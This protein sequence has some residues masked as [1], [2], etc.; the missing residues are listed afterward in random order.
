MIQRLMELEESNQTREQGVSIR[1]H[2]GKQL[3]MSGR[4]AERLLEVLSC[5]Q[6]I[7]AALDRGDLPLK[8]LQRISKA[9]KVFQERIA[10]ALAAAPSAHAKRIVKQLLPSPRARRMKPETVCWHLRRII[11]EELDSLEGRED[12]VDVQPDD[13]PG[14]ER[15]ME[16]A[17]RLIERGHEI[18]SWDE[19]DE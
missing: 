17:E 2:I 3:G 9:D 6:A 18:A 10:T 19:D 13:I 5:P 7:L 12:R 11:R 8:T 4:N 14:F 16:C 1:D 15:L